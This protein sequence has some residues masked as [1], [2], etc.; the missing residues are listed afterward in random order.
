M[1]SENRQRERGAK[2]AG[3]VAPRVTVKSLRRFRA[4]LIGPTRGFLN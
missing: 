4:T 3:K 2:E 1:A